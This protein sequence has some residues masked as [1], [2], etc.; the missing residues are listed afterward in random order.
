[1]NEL[2]PLFSDHFRDGL[3]SLIELLARAIEIGNKQSA[4]EATIVLNSLYHLFDQDELLA[5]LFEQTP[6]PE[7]LPL[8]DRIVNSKGFSLSSDLDCAVLL[9]IAGSHQ[10]HE[11]SDIRDS[12]ARIYVLVGKHDFSVL[13]D[14][15]CGLSPEAQ[16]GFLAFIKP[17]LPDFAIRHAS[18]HIP[19]FEQLPPEAFLHD[20]HAVIA[21]SRPQEWRHIRA[22]L[23]GEVN[24][25]L[26][27]E[28]SEG[29]LLV[30][31]SSV[32]RERGFEDYALLLSGLLFQMHSPEHHVA[33]NIIVALLNELK[34]ND[35]ILAIQAHIESPSVP[36]CQAAIELIARIVKKANPTNIGAILPSLFPILQAA[37]HREAPE[38]RR[39]VVVC[40]VEMKI[41]A[42]NEVDPVIAQLAKPQ[43]KLIAFYHKR[44]T[45]NQ[46]S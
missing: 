33:D 21:R 22:E 7:M 41:V 10:A 37:F 3:E 31:I 26:I 38:V 35:F 23:Y 4:L 17:H 15:Y 8:I 12:I 11:D 29:R 5:V 27:A 18:A 25:A 32:F 6:I 13:D 34:L 44:R 14:F 45:D 9:K 30:V 39:A 2:L 46:R 19:R 40:F 43:Q 42:P 1:L 36:T 20:V 28:S 16:D 24:K